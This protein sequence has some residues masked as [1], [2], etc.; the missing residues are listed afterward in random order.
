MKIFANLT[1]GV[2]DELHLKFEFKTGSGVTMTGASLDNMVCSGC[3]AFN[4]GTNT[5]T[6]DVTSTVTWS[7]NSYILVEFDAPNGC[8][9]DVL[10]RKAEIKPSGQTNL[11]YPSVSSMTFPYCTSEVSGEIAS[12]WHCF[13]PGV[14]VN[15]YPTDDPAACPN[16]DLTICGPYSTCVC[17]DY[18]GWTIKPERFDYDDINS[19]S[20][21]ISTYDLVLIS[22]H[23]LGITPLGSPY[24]MIAADANRSGSITNFDIVNLRK[25]ILGIYGPPTL[26]P[27]PVLGNDNPWPS[28]YSSSW[29][30][31]PKDYVFPNSQNPFQSNFPEAL[32][33]MDLPVQSANFVA[34]KTGHVENVLGEGDQ[35]LQR[36]QTLCSDCSANKPSESI[37][38]SLGL[39]VKPIT[40]SEYLTIPFLSNGISPLIAWQMGLQFNTRYLE[41]VGVSNGDLNGMSQENFG[42]TKASEGK[43]RA[44][45][46]ANVANENDFLK[47]GQCLFYLTFKAKQDIRDFST[48]INL[49]DNLLKNQGWEKEGNRSFYFELNFDHPLEDRA[50]TEPN[51]EVHSNP[52]PC[53]EVLNLDFK[54]PT[55]ENVNITI[56]DAFER[57]IYTKVVKLDEGAHWVSIPEI[58]QWPA[59]VYTWNLQVGKLLHAKGRTI[60]M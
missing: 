29:R 18:K 30:F 49:D 47:L 58:A 33:G 56:F 55:S 10:T 44:L 22:K 27:A 23:I 13:L 6:L 43:I 11:C 15:V 46:M 34:I 53:T 37:S 19:F 32:I 14:D 57:L 50:L 31:V 36:P 3:L 25:I 60:K 48:I 5:V 7:S 42:L 1:P 40:K 9:D 8:I 39:P 20:T 54:L 16:I 26:Q 41:F 28:T 4:T 21:G 24:F 2:Y 59:G 52:N 38:F 12:E 51:F 35:P 45:W 17:S